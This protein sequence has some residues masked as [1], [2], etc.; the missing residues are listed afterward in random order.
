MENLLQRATH[1]E[2]TLQ[3]S[4]AAATA[5]DKEAKA[6][7]S[8]PQYLTWSDNL[9]FLKGNQQQITTLKNTL[10]QLNEWES[11]NMP[12]NKLID[13][14]EDIN[15][16]RGIQMKMKDHMQ[17]PPDQAT[18]EGLKRKLFLNLREATKDDPTGNRW[19]GEN[20]TTR[21]LTVGAF[22]QAPALQEDNGQIHTVGDVL[23]TLQEDIERQLETWER[24]LETSQ[25]EFALLEQASEQA[26]AGHTGDAGEGLPGTVRNAWNSIPIR[27]H[28][29]YEVWQAMKKIAKSYKESYDQY[30]D[31]RSDILAKK[32]S[33]VIKH[34]PWGNDVQQLLER[35]LD[36]RNNGI[37]SKYAEY[38]KSKNAN[39]KEIFGPGGELARNKT[40]GNRAR[41]VLEYAASRGWLNDIDNNTRRGKFLA[42]QSIDGPMYSLRELVPADWDDAKILDY[43]AIL[44]TKH[45][46]GK[47]DESEKYLNRYYNVDVAERFLELMTEELNKL[48]I[49]AA[50]GIMKRALQRGLKGEISPW[51]AVKLLRLL[52]DNP[53]IRQVITK[54][55]LDQMGAL[56]LYNSHF[57]AG[58]LKTDDEKIYDYA[59][60]GRPDRIERTGLFGTTVKEIRRNIQSSI[61]ASSW[62]RLQTD[63][64]KDDLDRAI[65]QIL[66]AQ[67]VTI[68]GRHFTIFQDNAVY[69]AYRSPKTNEILRYQGDVKA[70]E[71]DEDYVREHYSDVMIGSKSAISSYLDQSN[72]HLRHE[73]RAKFFFG[74]VIDRYE[75]LVK[76]GQYEEADTFRQEMG[77]KLSSWL[78]GMLLDTRN[79]P[80]YEAEAE[81]KEF[82][83][84]LA[85]PK[86]CELGFFTHETLETGFELNKGTLAKRL[87]TIYNNTKPARDARIQEAAEARRMRL[88]NMR[89]AA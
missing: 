39:Y 61:S 72:G 36:E 51:V 68:D 48:N 52:E 8:G 15:I 13:L 74:T 83:N 25:K 6:L 34:L 47:K 50:H 16:A 4:L 79:D 55:A 17:L 33:K 78:S 65:A 5:F 38:L 73:S 22:E 14:F 84:I 76:D 9:E 57:T 28:S 18:D 30:T 81:S 67:T 43:E 21:L 62:S 85:V 44:L 23:K 63:A 88:S 46:Q 53:Y 10:V 86:L 27:F 31:L 11:A 19:A 58:A 66:S 64:G 54:D 75:T 1:I 37:A 60:S 7:L 12:R 56:A 89:R 42:I 29:P 20:T 80:L 59:K 41:G 2:D 32:M 82:G 77:E 87:W 26:Q 70:G 69:N 35:E 71:E 40:D 45:N 3:K 49:W 24:V